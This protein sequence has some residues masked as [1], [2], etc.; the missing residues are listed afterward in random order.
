MRFFYDPRL[1]QTLR[2]AYLLTVALPDHMQGVDGFPTHLSLLRDQ[3]TELAQ[4]SSS[5]YRE[6]VPG[7][8]QLYLNINCGGMSS[9]EI[10]DA[11]LSSGEYATLLGPLQEAWESETNQTNERQAAESQA[12]IISQEAANLETNEQY[13]IR[14]WQ[15]ELSLRAILE[16]LS[17]S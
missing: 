10:A 13:Y 12:H 1:M 14:T 5:E 17:Q 6:D 3:L 8:V 9:Q 16:Q 15:K 11:I 4:T 7:M 2:D